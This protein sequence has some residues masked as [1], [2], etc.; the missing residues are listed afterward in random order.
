MNRESWN[1]AD[2]LCPF[3]VGDE[4]KTKGIYCE[5]FTQGMTVTL[6]FRQQRQ[7]QE[8]MGLHCCGAYARCEVYKSTMKK[9]PS[10]F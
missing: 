9:Y 7:K 5:G 3:Y 1:A 6:K 10:D 8:Y 4:H 2:V